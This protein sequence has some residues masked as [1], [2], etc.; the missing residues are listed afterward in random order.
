MSY[1]FS[2]NLIK[3]EDVRQ[4]IIEFLKSNSD[5]S[6]TFDWTA[7][8]IS[9]VIDSMSYVS[10]LMSYQLSNVAMNNFLETT[11]FRKNA[12][13]KAKEIGYRPKRKRSAIVVGT[14]TYVDENETFTETSKITILPYSTFITSKGNTF[15]NLATIELT[16]KD[17]N[18]LT[19]TYELIEGK[20]RTI[21]FD[22][23]A[24]NKEFQSFIIPSLN[25]EENSLK[26][27]LQKNN[28]NIAPVEWTEA[29]SI[30]DIT[31]KKCF[32]LEEDTSA[33][34]YPKLIFGDGI[35]SDAP[36]VDE[37]IIVSYI[38]TTGSLANG[39]YVTSVP[40]DTTVYQ[41]NI[42]NFSLSK[43]TGLSDDTN[44]SFGGK[45]YETLEEIK[46]AAPN[47]FSTAGRAVTKNDFTTILNAYPY[48]LS[49]SVIGGNDLYPEDETQLGNIYI[50]G[51]PSTLNRTSFFDNV[52]I[53]LASTEEQNLDTYL[54][55][56][57]IISTKINFFKP[58]YIV[59]DVFPKIELQSNTSSNK[60]EELKVNTKADLVVY[61]LANFFDYGSFFRKSK[62]TAVMDQLK[63]VVSSSVTSNYYF[64]LNKDSFYNASDV[65]Y[66]SVSLP[67]VQ[68]AT[69]KVNFVQ[70]NKELASNLN[71]ALEDLPVSSRT[72]YGK[73]TN[74][75]LDRYLYSEDQVTGNDEVFYASIK[76]D[77]SKKFFDVY[78]YT[79]NS[80]TPII[81]NLAKWYNIDITVNPEISGLYDDY[82]ISYDGNEIGRMKRNINNYFQ[83]LVLSQSELPDLDVVS[84]N[85]GKY[86]EAITSFAVTGYG[87]TFN[88]KEGD[89]LMFNASGTGSWQKCNVINSVSA[90]TDFDLY[91]V[92]TNN[93]IYQIN[94]SGDGGGRLTTTANPGDY[95]IFNK[96]SE[97]NPVYKW[98]FLNYRSISLDNSRSLPT[99]ALDYDLKLVVSEN[100]VPSDFGGRTNTDFY[101]QD[102]IMYDVRNLTDAD[103]WVKVWNLNDINSTP[104]SA[105]INAN[106]DVLFQ[107]DY[108]PVSGVEIG[109][110]RKVTEYGNFFLYDKIYWPTGS[111]TIANVNDILIYMGDGY[112][113]IFQ[114]AFSG[115]Y[116]ID[117][118]NI[119]SLPLSLTYGDYFIVLG[120]PGVTNNFNGTSAEQFNDGDFVVYTDQSWKRL[121]YIDSISAADGSEFPIIAE[122][123]SILKVTEDGYFGNGTNPYIDFNSSL[124][125]VD[126]DYI[127]FVDNVNESKWIRAKEYTFLFADQGKDVLNQLGF[128]STF[129]YKYNPDTKYYELIFYDKFHDKIIGQFVYNAA[130]NSYDIGQIKF[131]PTTVGNLNSIDSTESVEVKTLFADSD[132]LDKIRF[133][134]K[135]KT[136][137]FESEEDFNCQFN[138]FL[139]VNIN[140]TEKL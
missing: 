16:Y 86:V 137:S 39:D 133:K 56:F 40:A 27:N 44:L 6:S 106:S 96:Y 104:V 135:N 52:K 116:E 105:D 131:E 34:F 124:P 100:L 59:V 43:F 77:S 35:I 61:A 13:S 101:D 92:T 84:T 22:S 5:Y 87:D 70:T 20:P 103:R 71:I 23:E 140:N 31:T 113:R 18:T 68:T 134:P 108:H 128:S 93:D 117:S 73:V 57:N 54:N 79:N 36:A 67:V 17:Q 63:D 49:S 19:A 72:I 66:N 42:N 122:L 91:S 83:G 80:Q 111:S 64:I 41:S 121:E 94:A 129:N 130:S 10:M 46:A 102:L 114:T 8:N 38:E 136:N 3:F 26:V 11:N 55:A 82:F 81:T 15:L 132:V 139:V 119:N 50:S 29:K 98:E 2:T 95:I 88:V 127:I 37:Q 112:W 9:Y 58:S 126:G 21:S 138:Q 28:S 107:L 25:V 123:G 78:R 76:L 109:S 24:G 99:A 90:L 115:F 7:S 53:Y 85:Q 33:E 62:L 65:A 14:L 45:D 89:L 4:Q 32:F 120:A 30:F 48:I 1:S 110:F 12:V 75:I 118:S 60:I 125:Y 47:Y 51:V 97:S 74:D 69:G